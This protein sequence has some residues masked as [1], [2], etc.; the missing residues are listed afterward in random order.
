MTSNVVQFPKKGS[1]VDEAMAWLIDQHAKGRISELLLLAVDTDGHYEVAMT[2][3]T[4]VHALYNA[5]FLREE[6][7]KVLRNEGLM[8][9]ASG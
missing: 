5:T 4:G 7:M 8:P 3:T 1:S 2:K 6:V 9:D